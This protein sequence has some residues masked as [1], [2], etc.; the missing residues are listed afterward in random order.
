MLLRGRPDQSVAGAGEQSCT[1]SGS[2]WVLIDA[3]GCALRP[4]VLAALTIELQ[5]HIRLVLIEQSRPQLFGI[6]AVSPH[7]RLARGGR[8]T[9]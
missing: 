2:S 5:D 1:P 9:G 4:H 7:T 6:S 8:E 3:R